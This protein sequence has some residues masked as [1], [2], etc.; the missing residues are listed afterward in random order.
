MCRII[1]A[2]QENLENLHHV[3][4][5]R[6][7][8]VPVFQLTRHFDLLKE[9]KNLV[10]YVYHMIETV[11]YSSGS[12]S[13]V[14][15]K[16]KLFLNIFILSC[17]VVG[18]LFQPMRYPDGWLLTNQNPRTRILYSPCHEQMRQNLKNIFCFKSFDP[19]V[20]LYL[21]K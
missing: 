18:L 8:I 6:F 21:A 1:V 5:I 14:S 12:I 11:F 20:Q 15:M 7:C 19:P 13:V 4:R 16:I 17:A 2:T 3:I 9:Y 10:K